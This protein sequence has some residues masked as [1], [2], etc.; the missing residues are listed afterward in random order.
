[1][2]RFPSNCGLVCRQHAANQLVGQSRFNKC[3]RCAQCALMAARSASGH[4][5]RAAEQHEMIGLWQTASRFSVATDEFTRRHSRK[6]CGRGRLRERDEIIQILCPAACDVRRPIGHDSRALN[7]AALVIDRSVMREPTRATRAP[8]ERRRY[9]RR[10][11][12]QSE[13]RVSARARLTRITA[14]RARNARPFDSAITARHSK[15]RRAS[16]HLHLSGVLNSAE[17]ERGHCAQAAGAFDY[18]YGAPFLRG[19]AR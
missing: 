17:R 13:K 7:T 6:G 10:P 15:S 8:N 12:S 18:G 3:A 19:K 14:G 5:E 9:L 1:M 4:F 16:I 11:I 2:C